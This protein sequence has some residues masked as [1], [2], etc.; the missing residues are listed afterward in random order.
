MYITHVNSGTGQHLEA[1]EQVEQG[2]CMDRG[3]FVTGVEAQWP[4]N[5]PDNV[6]LLVL[7]LFYSLQRRSN[8]FITG[9]ANNFGGGGGGQTSSRGGGGKC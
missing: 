5:S 7:N 9:G 2:P 1:Y 3:I 6:F 4:E 8:G